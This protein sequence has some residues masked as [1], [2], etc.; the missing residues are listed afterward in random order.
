[1]PLFLGFLLMGRLKIA[2]ADDI[3]VELVTK[4]PDNLKGK[5]YQNYKGHFWYTV[6]S[7]LVE[8]ELYAAISPTTDQAK[9]G[10]E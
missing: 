2:A 1:M 7:N 8:C 9:L 5:E 6:N 10:K 4:L 3:V